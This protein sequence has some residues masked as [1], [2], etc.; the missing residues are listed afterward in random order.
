[1][2]LLNS[3]CYVTSVLPVVGKRQIKAKRASGESKKLSFRTIFYLSYSYSLLVEESQNN[4]HR[5][6][7]FC[8]ENINGPQIYSSEA[9]VQADLKVFRKVPT[10][11]LTLQCSRLSPSTSLLTG[12]QTLAHRLCPG[13]LRTFQ[14]SYSPWHYPLEFLI[15]QIWIRTQNLHFS[16]A[17]LVIQQPILADPQHV[18]TAVRA[19][20]RC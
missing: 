10:T 6:L 12:F 20:D 3:S 13:V 11:D 19:A 17:P 14:K 5:H 4:T 9:R 2:Y 1:M 8:K 15:Q 18:T 16:E 7:V